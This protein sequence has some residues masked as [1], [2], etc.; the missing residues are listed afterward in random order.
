MTRKTSTDRVEK[1]LER[2]GALVA[3]RQDL[4]EHGSGDIELEHNRREIADLQQELS[5]ALIDLHLP[6]QR[7]R[8]A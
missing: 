7:R 1:I 3:E 4:R 6:K 5:R 2:I 8:A